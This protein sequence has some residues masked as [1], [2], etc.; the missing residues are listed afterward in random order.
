MYTMEMETATPTR[1]LCY[2]YDLFVNIK[3]QH[4]P[5]LPQ[6]V[7]DILHNIDDQLEDK[8]AII[9]KKK[10]KTGNTF[11]KNN[12]GGNGSSSKSFGASSTSGAVAPA[13]LNHAQKLKQ[14]IAKFNKDLN[15]TLNGLTDT[16]LSNIKQKLLNVLL[17]THIEQEHILPIVVEQIISKALMQIIYTEQY[18]KLISEVAPSLE[19]GTEFIIGI[20]QQLT[21]NMKV[22]EEKQIPK[23][24]FRGICVLY[25][26][27]YEN[28][29]LDKSEIIEFINYNMQLLF[30]AT[31]EL[32]DIVSNGIVDIYM[33]IY[34]KHMNKDIVENYIETIVDM[35][36][37]ITVPMNVRIR[38]CDVRDAYIS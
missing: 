28:N 1:P 13:S 23:Q 36:D 14:D 8:M 17:N 2:G 11:N 19:Y 22:V 35:C 30:T 38:L 12:V 3:D 33:Y 7:I 29:V 31:P 16:N 4:Y 18:A 10:K 9:K 27:L 37:D 20:K 6:Q 5:T 34:N 21:N 25:I 15:L 26:S 32:K 24:V